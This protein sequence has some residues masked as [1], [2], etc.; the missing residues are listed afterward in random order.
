MY[1]EPV[2]GVGS[3]STAGWQTRI[4]TAFDGNF[5]RLARVISPHSDPRDI[6]FKL[7][8]ERANSLGL[9]ASVAGESVYLKIYDGTA[10]HVPTQY[11][12]E[13]NALLMLRE[14]G[15]SVHLLACH[16]ELQFLLT[17]HEQ[18]K[19]DKDDFAS[20][21]HLETLEAVGEWL[22]HLD[23]ALPSQ[24]AFGTWYQYLTK[25]DEDLNPYV[26]QDACEELSAVPILGTAFARNNPILTDFVIDDQGR[27]RGYNFEAARIRPLGWDYVLTSLAICERYGDQAADALEAL[28]AGF[29]HK[30]KGAL[31]AHELNMIARILLCAR[32]TAMCDRRRVGTR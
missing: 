4:R 25:F 7:L 13:K 18:L 19:I 5:A 11:T 21:F 9:K 22:A 29:E 31:L 28:S 17:R 14:S 10:A 12:R 32:A 15:L 23:A 6:S 30:H 27:L 1:D 24:S 2:S 20:P 26:I 3:K 16:D 8:A